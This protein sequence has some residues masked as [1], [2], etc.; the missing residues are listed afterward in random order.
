MLE[1]Q[2][3]RRHN[4]DQRKKGGAAGANLSRKRI[5]EAPGATGE[6][7]KKRRR[8][9]PHAE[10]SRAGFEGKKQGFINNKEKKTATAN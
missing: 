4:L 6:D 1:R 10:K 2:K 8:M 7:G 9:G 5:V 3:L